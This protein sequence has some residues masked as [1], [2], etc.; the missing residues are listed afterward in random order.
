MVLNGISARGDLT[1]EVVTHHARDI[2]E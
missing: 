2:A 1:K